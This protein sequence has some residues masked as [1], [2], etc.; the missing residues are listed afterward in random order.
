[1]VCLFLSNPTC[2]VCAEDQDRTGDPSLFRGML[3][4]LSYLGKRLSDDLFEHITEHRIAR[5]LSIRIGYGPRVGLDEVKCPHGKTYD[6][7][8]VQETHSD[9][10]AIASSDAVKYL[11]II[12]REPVGAL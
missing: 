7:Q 11:V 12:F 4:Q 2:N 1:M 10:P 3:Y 5:N 8:P 6:D 9:R